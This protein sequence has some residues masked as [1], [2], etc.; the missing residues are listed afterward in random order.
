MCF[1]LCCVRNGVHCT[2]KMPSSS[3]IISPRATRQSPL[4]RCRARYSS[5][6]QSAEHACRTCLLIR[7]NYLLCP[8]LRLQQLCMNDC[9]HNHVSA[10]T[11][12]PPLVRPLQTDSRECAIHRAVLVNRTLR[13][14]QVLSSQ[15]SLSVK[16]LGW[17]KQSY[18][19]LLSTSQATPVSTWSDLSQNIICIK[20]A[21]A[22]C[23]RA[24]KPCRRISVSI[25]SSKI[26]PCP[27]ERWLCPSQRLLS[28]FQAG[29]PGGPKETLSPTSA[30]MAHPSSYV[31]SPTTK[32]LCYQAQAQN[33]ATAHLHAGPHADEL[34]QGFAAPSLQVAGVI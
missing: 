20:V 30:R 12:S 25:Y 11:L 24:Y 5:R 28:S 8:W 1:F 10:L 33:C 34:Q 9:T 13:E 19:D 32:L 21:C 23:A 6:R 29:G 3:I 16:G 22:I 14:P 27:T 15:H 31:Q 26:F 18:K 7:C 2:R 17:G 4:S